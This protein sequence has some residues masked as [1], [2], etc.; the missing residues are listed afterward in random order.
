MANQNSTTSKADR[1]RGLRAPIADYVGKIQSQIDGLRADGTDKVISL[2]EHIDKIKRDRT[3]SKEEK[4]AVI[5]KDTSLMEKAKQV[6]ASNKDEI[7]KLIADAENYLKEHFDKDYY[8]IIK[9]ECIQEK[10]AAKERYQA[11]VAELEREH[12]Q[13]VSKLTDHQEIKDEKYVYKNKL[14]DAK[15]GYQD[16]LQ[17]IKDHRHEAFTYQYHLI[18]LLRM[19]KFTF[20]ENAAQKWENFMLKEN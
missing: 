12:Q 6:E 19:S 15:M 1:E 9:A 3:L 5:A 13:A 18:D 17:H 7:A 4:D 2:Q 8:Q 11:K 10:V 14:F 16:E 20:A